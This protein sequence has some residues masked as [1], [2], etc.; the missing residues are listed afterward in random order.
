MNK[1]LSFL[2]GLFCR[3]KMRFKKVPIHIMYFKG[4]LFN[5]HLAAYSLMELADSVIWVKVYKEQWWSNLALWI[6]NY[7]MLKFPVVSKFWSLNSNSFRLQ[8]WVEICGVLN[9]I[10]VSSL[11]K[12]VIFYCRWKLWDKFPRIILTHHLQIYL[13]A[14]TNTA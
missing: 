7:L 4:Y 8:S 13:A 1:V 14:S 5:D 9:G 12:N 2:Y 10:W 3:L 6:W 11:R